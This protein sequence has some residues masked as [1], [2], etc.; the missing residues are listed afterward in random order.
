MG[1][2]FHG[3]NVIM[4]RA[5]M[6]WIA[7]Q[8][9]LEERDNF[10]RSF[11]RL[12]IAQPEFPRMKIHHAFGIERHRIEIVRI[13]FHELRYRVP[14]IEIELTQIGFGIVRITNR[15]RVDVSPLRIR[16]VFLQR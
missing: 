11:V 10:L 5:E 14:V 2:C 8:D 16:S 6:I 9:G 15:E 12:P 3:V 7:F 4:V 1:R 13:D